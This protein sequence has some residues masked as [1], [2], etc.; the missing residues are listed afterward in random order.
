[1]RRFIG[2]TLAGLALGT[3]AGAGD[4]TVTAERTLVDFAAADSALSAWRAV[5]DVVM[6]GVSRSRIRRT[7]DGTAVF[8]GDLSLENNGGFA[9]V[10]ALTGAMDLSGCDG[11]VVRVRGDG[12]RYRLRFRTDERF[13]GIAYQATFATTADE[14]TEAELP[15]AA[16][17]PT[18]R[19]WEPPDAPPFDAGAIRQIGFMVAD[20]QEGA[21]RL[22]IAW[23]RG[24]GT[25]GPAPR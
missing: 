12:R 19:G 6:G 8:E 13:D 3:V 7:E 16:F 22:E 9:S 21:F 14:W 20:G 15:F 24:R 23:V 4:G 10:R 5:D 2:A 18:F 25:G 1:M 11:V 17:R